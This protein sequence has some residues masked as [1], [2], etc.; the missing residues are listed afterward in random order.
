MGSPTAGHGNA[1]TLDALVVLAR[2]KEAEIK[3]AGKQNMTIP[4]ADTFYLFSNCLH[5]MMGG[6]VFKRPN[7]NGLL[8]GSIVLLYYLAVREFVK[9]LLTGREHI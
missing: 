4:L 1:G 9:K 5:A 6:Y 8:L 2:T 7:R 3:K